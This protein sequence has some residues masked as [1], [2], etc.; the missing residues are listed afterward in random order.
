MKPN[1]TLA[2]PAPDGVLCFANTPAEPSGLP[3]ILENRRLGLLELRPSEKKDPQ[4]FKSLDRHSTAKAVLTSPGCHP[5]RSYAPR[6]GSVRGS[7]L[8]PCSYPPPPP[9]PGGPAECISSLSRWPSAASAP[10]PSA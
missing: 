4:H 2:R 9:T 1:L 8:P 7:P 10:E 5:H 3:T 6:P